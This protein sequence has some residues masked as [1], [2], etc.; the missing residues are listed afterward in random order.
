MF[1]VFFSC[2]EKT[3]RKTKSL[4][5]AAEMVDSGDVIERLLAPNFLL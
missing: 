5:S 3:K 4:E 1:S 2:N